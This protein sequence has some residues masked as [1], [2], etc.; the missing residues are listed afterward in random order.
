[1]RKFLGVLA[2]SVAAALT[3]VGC[4]HEHREDPTKETPGGMYTCP[5]HGG[6]YASVNDHCKVCG[7]HVEK[8]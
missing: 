6:S 5:R 7:S 2:I 3:P 1:M 8:K 4:T